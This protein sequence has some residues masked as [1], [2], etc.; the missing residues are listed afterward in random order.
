MPRREPE[1]HLR[2][3]G[4]LPVLLNGRVQPFDSV[5]RNALLQIRSTGDVPLELLTNRVGRVEEWPGWKFWHHPKK[6][7]STEWLL[8]VMT[9]PEQ[10]NQRPIFLIHHPELL[11]TLKLD[12]TGVERSALRYYSYVQIEPLIPEI[13][14][15][16]SEFDDINDKQRTPYQRQLLKLHRAITLYQRLELSLQPPGTHDLAGT[17]MQF[18]QLAPAGARAVRAYES[19]QS[20]DTNVL[21][22]FV[23]LAGGFLQVANSALPLTIPPYDPQAASDQWVNFG[24]GVMDS[25]RSGE[26]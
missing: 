20:Y 8:E 15:L 26:M 2:S 16:A 7:K 24:A 18:G 14:E 10:A 13:N 3:F 22:Q 25:I 12:E 1:F 19:G 17:V 11:R 23:G 9:K 21:T 5:G 6:I 4:A